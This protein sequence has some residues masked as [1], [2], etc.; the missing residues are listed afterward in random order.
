[1]GTEEGSRTNLQGG[2]APVTTDEEAL[3]DKVMLDADE[4]LMAS[5]QRD[6]LR[7]RRKRRWTLGGI[8]M[9][10]TMAAIVVGVLMS[11]PGAATR[12][13]TTQPTLDES[14]KAA[15]LSSEG[16]QL[17]NKHQLAAAEDKFEAAVKL[18]PGLT[19]AWN[20]LGWSRMNL[21][22]SPGAEGAFN[23]CV[24]IDDGYPAA[25]NGLGYL[26]FERRD[27]PAAE[28]H[29]L[30]V[31]DQAPASWYGL[32]KMYLLQGKWDQAAKWASKVT[33]DQPDDK[34]AK[35]ML[36][37]AEA[38]KLD[39]PLRRLIEPAPPTASSKETT[40]GW[41]LFNRGLLDRAAVEFRKALE[42]NPNDI[43]AHNG[44]GFCLLNGGNWQEAKKQFEI[45][46]KA[47]PNH[48]GAMNGLA[49]CLKAE[50]KV[51]DAIALWEKMVKDNP[52][53]NAGTAGLAWTYLERGDYGKAVKYFEQL[54]KS[55]PNNEAVK[56]ALKQAREGLSSSRPSGS[57]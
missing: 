41:S 57:R 27:Y 13:A 29:W 51:D 4:R 20:G 31:A 33:A 50:G 44:L 18:D 40:Q 19:S 35:Q 56:Q 52:G 5:L 22:D 46:L 16:W 53:P 48:A 11:G 10:L 43:A 2:V 49:R 6:E 3:L 47:Q 30:K 26:F 45:C 14:K 34:L 54:A 38:R 9:T 39:D 37:A 8:A 24:S 36:A 17:W 21:G 25:R 28:K 42:K 15:V 1:M 12:N 23:K 55:D 32:A 7:R